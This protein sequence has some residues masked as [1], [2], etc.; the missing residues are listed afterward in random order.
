MDISPTWVRINLVVSSSFGSE[1]KLNMCFL[2]LEYE[3]V[4]SV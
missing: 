3:Q 2:A 4:D 1:I